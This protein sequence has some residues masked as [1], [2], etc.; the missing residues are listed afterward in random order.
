MNTKELQLVTFEQA[1]RLKKAGFNWLTED[2]YDKKG[3]YLIDIEKCQNK[4]QNR[5]SAPT[6]ALA[7]K[8]FRDEKNQIGTVSIRYAGENTLKGFVGYINTGEIYVLADAYESAES[9]LLDEL[10]DILETN[11]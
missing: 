10:L 6:I 3:I 2:F 9:A 7:L 5:Y 8:W 1:K 4:R 11:T